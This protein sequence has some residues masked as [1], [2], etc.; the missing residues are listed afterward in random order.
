[1][2]ESVRVRRARAQDA[3]SLAELRWEFRSAEDPPVEDREAFVD[4]C[5]CWM[6]LRLERSESAWMCWVVD[7]GS[8][9]VGQ[10]WIG[11]VEKIPNPVREPER[12]AYL[13]NM[14]LRREFRGSG[15]GS[16]L[17]RAGLAS[18]R[19]LEIDS[20]ILWP[21]RRSR[22]LYAR[23]GFEPTGDILELRLEDASTETLRASETCFSEA[24]GP[25][26]NRIELRESSDRGDDGADVGGDRARSRGDH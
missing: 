6:S 8:E 17:L 15:I 22:P 4:R 19:N 13:T 11:I 3:G 16:E 20:V 26:V 1:M 5:R 23:H 12:H 18:C 9:L 10:M 7:E 2:P 14:F 25:E 21:T 24:R